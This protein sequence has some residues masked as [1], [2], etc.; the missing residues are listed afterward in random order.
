MVFKDK[1]KYLIPAGAL[2]LGA[3][4]TLSIV[5]WNTR[6]IKDDPVN[7]EQQTENQ[8]EQSDP[9]LCSKNT[10]KSRRAARTRKC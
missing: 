10:K 5:L 1:K 3:A 4:I 2:F 9:C 7:K 6:S 8:Q